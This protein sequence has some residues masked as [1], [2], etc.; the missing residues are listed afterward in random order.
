M[1]RRRTSRTRDHRRILDRF[2][3]QFTAADPSR[4]E[5]RNPMFSS[6]IFAINM[7]KQAKSLQLPS[8]LASSRIITAS[9][10]PHGF[11]DHHLANRSISSICGLNCSNNKSTPAF[12][13]AATRSATCSAVPTNPDRSPRF[14]TE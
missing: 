7:P 2:L 1:A 13:N 3:H 4:P 14:E 9:R 5:P 12:S 6:S 11:L 8:S 10:C